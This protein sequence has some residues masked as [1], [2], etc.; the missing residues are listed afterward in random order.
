MTSESSPPSIHLLPPLDQVRVL[1]L[2]RLLTGPYCSRILADFGA[3]V[4]RIE[5]PGGGD[6]LRHARRGPA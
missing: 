4:I 5:Q 3:E 6:W 2:S 1:D